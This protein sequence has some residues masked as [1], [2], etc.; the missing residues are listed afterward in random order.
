MAWQSR[1]IQQA[2][3]TAVCRNLHREHV[4]FSLQSAPRCAGSS[5]PVHS[6]SPSLHS[7]LA[8]SFS[9][10]ILPALSSPSCSHAL[11]AFFLLL[12]AMPASTQP[13]NQHLQLHPHRQAPYGSRQYICNLAGD[14]VAMTAVRNLKT[15]VPWIDARSHPVIYRCKT[16]YGQALRCG[17]FTIYRNRYT[18]G[19]FWAY[20]LFWRAYRWATSRGKGGTGLFMT[21]FPQGLF[22]WVSVPPTRCLFLFACC[23]VWRQP[24]MC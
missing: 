16:W 7:S 12:A 23:G 5:A 8:L 3:T 6:L 2:V 21:L 20:T 15:P 19:V 22:A 1:A 18:L 11:P 10:S 4:H 14:D 9:H 17:T 13:P 24:R